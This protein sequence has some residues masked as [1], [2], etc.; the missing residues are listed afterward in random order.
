MYK[1][2]FG[3]VD[4]LKKINFTI[5]SMLILQVLESTFNSGI[6]SLS[7]GASS[8]WNMNTVYKRVDLQV[9]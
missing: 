4:K 1:K 5:N 2:L 7:R 3:K 6:R 9:F 8:F